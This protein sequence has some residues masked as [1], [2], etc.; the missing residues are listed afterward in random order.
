MLDVHRRMHAARGRGVTGSAM[1]AAIADEL[2]A[3]CGWLLCFDE[4]QVTDIADAMIMRQLFSRLW[5]RGTVMV[6]TS[7]RPPRHLYHNG[8]Q[9]VLFLP[10]I[11]ELLHNCRVESLEASGVDY[12]LVRGA[13]A[14]ED[15]FLC[16]PKLGSEELRR[17]RFEAL[18]LHLTRYARVAPVTL[19]VQGRPVK[20]PQA[21]IGSR[22]ARFR[23]EELCGGG[24]A[25]AMGAADY[26]AISQAFHT[27]FLEGLPAMGLESLDQVRRLITLVDTLYE[28][29]VKLVCLAAESPTGLFHPAGMDCGRRPADRSKLPDE[30]FAFDRTVSRLIEV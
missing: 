24:G 15:V 30:V 22:V 6:A 14:V 20:V 7:N 2:V 5:A 21:V 11:D 26:H 12:R 17:A 16:P 18:W 9:R 27:I 13:D 4:F 1:V 3:E 25:A 23:F 10:F 8:L 19:R 29:D 28:R